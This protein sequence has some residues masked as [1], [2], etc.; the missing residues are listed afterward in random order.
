MPKYSNKE[1]VQILKEVLAGMEVKGFSFFRI[2]A[3]QNAIAVLENL[4]SSIYDIWQNGKLNDILGIGE[5]LSQH[6]TE[7]FTTGTAK[8]FERAKKDLP[9][10][11]FAL[12]GLRTIGAKRAY[13]L[14]SIFKL[15]KRAD[16]VE[17]LRNHA[18]HHNICQLEGFGEK[19]EKEMIE[20]IRDMAM[21]DATF[22]IVGSESINAAL[23]AGLILKED[24]RKIKE[25]PFVMVLM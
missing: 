13:R 11:M 17:K 6:L 4:T 24:I 25:I 15:T 2:R 7:L 5:G 22:N 23:K 12:L 18:K 8:E 10:G 1:V 19:S 16:A 9:D 21:E 14:A 3:Y 20:I